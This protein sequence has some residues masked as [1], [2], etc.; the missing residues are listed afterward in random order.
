MPRWPGDQ[1]ETGSQ[2]VAPSPTSPICP[3]KRRKLLIHRFVKQK[4][5]H[6]KQS[7]G[8]DVGGG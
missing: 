7:G 3:K 5:R 8:G 2:R 6:Y 1:A 4:G